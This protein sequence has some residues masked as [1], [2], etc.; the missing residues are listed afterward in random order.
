MRILLTGHKGFVGSHVQR[1]LEADGNEVVGLEATS[2]F[3]AW[4]DE[5]DVIMNTRID[6]TIHLGAISNNQ[7][8]DPDIFLWNSYATFLLAQRARR[9]PAQ[10]PFIFFSSF[11]V[12]NTMRDWEVRTPYTW[13]K[14]QAEDFV[15][16]C[17][18]HAT[19]LR[20]GVMWG[21]EQ[22]KAGGNGSVPWRLANHSLEYMF[23]NWQRK[24]VHVDDVVKAVKLCLEDRP[25]GIFDLAPAHLHTNEQLADLVEWD[26]FEWI[27]DPQEVGHKFISSHENRDE[28][29]TP[30]GWE[31]KV[32]I[33]DAL[34]R[35]EWILNR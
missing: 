10:I 17:L 21:N 35:L 11:L 24:Y 7:Y 32:A 9:K 14:A 18:P 23:R 13:S 34:P 12:G 25:K 16:V 29:P 28:L 19:I 6:A 27:E 1:A 22:N 3:Q 15:Q 33:E 8:N 30:P 4:H 5:M 2:T 20:P 26:G 31:P